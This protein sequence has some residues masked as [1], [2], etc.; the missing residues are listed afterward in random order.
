MEYFAKV[1]TAK[2]S[3]AAEGFVGLFLNKQFLDGVFPLSLPVL[4]QRKSS[5][6]YKLPTYKILK[7]KD[8]SQRS[9]SIDVSCEFEKR[10]KAANVY[11]HNMECE[12]R[13]LYV[14]KNEIEGAN[15]HLQIISGTN[16]GRHF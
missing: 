13:S 6:A 8:F 16:F 1:V 3:S 12:L 4:S 14:M 15:R 10:G 7:L 2:T 5:L 11:N 9:N